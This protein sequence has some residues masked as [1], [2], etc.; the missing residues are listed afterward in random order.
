MKPPLL[1]RWLLKLLPFLLSGCLKT[2]PDYKVRGNQVFYV[3]YRGN[4]LWNEANEALVDGADGSTFETISPGK[5]AKDAKHIIYQSLLLPGSDS[6]TFKLLDDQGAYGKDAHQVYFRGVI[7]G[8]DPATFEFVGGVNE[9]RDSLLFYRV[10]KDKNDYYLGYHPLHVPDLAAFKIVADG[11]A[12]SDIWAHDRLNYYVGEEAFPIADVATFQ[13]L[14]SGFAKDA[15]QVYH[16]K[17][18]IASAAPKTFEAFDDDYAK[19]AKHAYHGGDR[20]TDPGIKVMEQVDAATFKG[21]KSH[22]A[23]DAKRVYFDG[24]VVPEADPQTFEALDYCYGKDAKHA[25][26]WNNVMDGID[27]AS[28]TVV[29]PDNVSGSRFS[30]GYAKDKNKVYCG[31]YLVPDADAASFQAIKGKAWDKSKTY[32]GTQGQ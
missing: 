26:N 24:G 23:K 31:S 1:I 4:G 6:K 17:E 19:D 14:K 5:Y 12:K 16:L 22:Y 32:Y 15:K 20:I 29:G 21:L 30:S 18:I 3:N 2:E 11:G 25:F 9:K 13:V 28:F 8:A 10:A 27:L 7:E